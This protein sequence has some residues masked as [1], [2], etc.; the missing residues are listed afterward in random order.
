LAEAAV[1]SP[2]IEIDDTI[3]KDFRETFE[4]ARKA[5]AAV[6]AP[7]VEDEDADGA[8][9]KVSRISQ[10]IYWG[11]HAACFLAFF[12]GASVTD[13][14]VCLVLFWARMFGIT[15][16]YH[17]Y[18]SHKTYK[19]SRV[20]QFGLA[21]LGTLS[22]QK[23]P[24]WWAAGHRRHH[25]YSDQEGDMHSPR[26]SFWYSHQGW[27]FD[28]RWGPTELDRIKDFAKYPE[29]MWLNR[30]HIVPPLAL[31]FILGF[32]FG[33]SAVVWGM[34]ISTTLLWHAT[35]TINSLAHRFGSRRF[36]TTD[37][38]RNNVWLAL[39]TLGEGW[40]NNHHHYQASTRQGFYWWEVDVT[41]YVLRGL[42]RLG[43][44]WDLR[45]PPESVLDAGRASG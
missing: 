6:A 43:V 27:I 3:R 9:F 36:E 17:R 29:L 19:T 20:F 41:Y 40:H 35:Y 16:G 38:S 15:A 2:V 11:I 24:L 1:E 7:V 44:V 39:L 10:A 23:G 33:F 4:E 21:L 32:T 37:D 26:E 42:A 18:F 45:E 12:T 22:I 31:T 34:A 30:W 25:R 8:W 28:D 14:V 5:P 13:V